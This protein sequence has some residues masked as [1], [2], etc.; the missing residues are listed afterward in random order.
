MTVENLAELRKTRK[1]PAFH[2]P[3][4]PHGK[5][6]LYAVADVDAWVARSRVETRS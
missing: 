1:G 6:T 5:V 3:T 2:K 4:G